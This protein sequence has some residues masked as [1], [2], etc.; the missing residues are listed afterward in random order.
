[1]GCTTWTTRE[2]TRGH[3]RLLARGVLAFSPVLAH[4]RILVA[5]DDQTLLE[6]VAEAL[7]EL[8]ANVVSARSGAELIESL[9]DSG[10]FDLVITDISMPWMSGLQAIHSVR[11]AGLATPVIV[12]TALG[13]DRIEAQVR[14]LGRDAVLLRKPFALADLANAATELLVRRASHGHLAAGR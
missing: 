3:V 10:P 5:D 13:S 1:M 2:R 12:M 9:G 7:E 8:G 11:A 6:T 14:M 4:A